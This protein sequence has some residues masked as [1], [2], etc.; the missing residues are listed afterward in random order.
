ML[1][2]HLGGY[3]GEV[4][5]HRLE[6]CTHKTLAGVPCVCNLPNWFSP[7]Q[8][9]GAESKILPPLP[10]LQWEHDTQGLLQE[11]PSSASL[12][13]GR[14]VLSCQDPASL[15]VP[16]VSYPSEDIRAA[17]FGECELLHSTDF[18]LAHL[19]VG[20]RLF[21]GFTDV[22]FYPL[23]SLSLSLLLP[24]SDLKAPQIFLLLS[25]YSAQ[26]FPLINVFCA[27]FLI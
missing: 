25:I 21:Q 10:W 24:M 4:G 7:I 5:G 22:S 12:H 8:T 3:V 26:T 11:R 9:S 17:Q 1:F 15:A 6:F 27:Y 16:V 18:A 20:M 19:L 2:R 14:A 23:L 13:L